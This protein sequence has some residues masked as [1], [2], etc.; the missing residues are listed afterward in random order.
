MHARQLAFRAFTCIFP[1]MIIAWESRAST[2]APTSTPDNV[3]TTS[4]EGETRTWTDNTGR[5]HTQAC[6]VNVRD[7]KA[8]L[9]T[10]G[11]KVTIILLDR[12]SQS[13]QKYVREF[14]G[15]TRIEPE[16]PAPPE[17]SSPKRA[18]TDAPWVDVSPANPPSSR[19]V[20]SPTSP[21]KPGQVESEVPAPPEKPLQKRAGDDGP[22]VDVS[23][24]PAAPSLPVNPL[25]WLSEVIIPNQKMTGS[26]QEIWAM[27]PDAAGAQVSSLRAATSSAS[28]QG[29]LAAALL[30]AVANERA[31]KRDIALGEYRQL[32]ADGK[33]TAFGITASSRAI[34]LE[35]QAVKD[36]LSALPAADAWFLVSDT[37]TWTTSWAAAD[38]ISA[39][40]KPQTVFSLWKA[41]GCFILGL[42]WLGLCGFLG[43]WGGV[44]GIGGGVGAVLGVIMGCIILFKV[45]DYAIT[46]WHSGHQCGFWIG[47]AVSLVLGLLVAAAN[48]QNTTK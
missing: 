44:L 6:L 22:W 8:H 5:F 9:R 17:K 3:A 18:K 33:G 24:S 29:R 4:T 7:G 11:G 25:K 36:K 12:L 1:V 14:Q 16:L 10:E 41:I 42:F 34:V 20:E 13:D 40:T 15:R 48:A 35:G 39:T 23:P 26:L 21:S 2:D 31:G 43:R 46:T 28:T 45:E 27:P 47:V 37:W 19:A 30:I 32:A 38:A